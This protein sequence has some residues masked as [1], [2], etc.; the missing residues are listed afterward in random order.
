M[1]QIEAFLKDWF[2][3]P[4]YW[5]ANNPNIDLYLTQTYHSL[6]HEI[7]QQPILDIYN[8]TDTSFK[9][10][11]ILIHDQLSRHFFR[12][13]K[14]QLSYFDK[15]SIFLLESIID[16]IED[17]TPVERCFLLMPYRHT[18]QLKY[19]TIVLD[20]ISKW[21]HQHPTISIYKRFYIATLQSI[22][23]INTQE[24]S[25]SPYQPSQQFSHEEIQ[26]V[27]DT[28]SPSPFTFM[29]LSQIQVFQHP[30][31][32]EFDNKLSQHLLSHEKKIIVS[33]SGGVDSM[34][35]CYLL[36][37]WNIKH[38]FSYE[39]EAITIHYDNRHEQTIE[40]YMVN[41]WCKILGIPHYV[42]KISEIK[43]SNDYDRDIYEEL[44]RKIRFDMYQKRQGVVLLGHNKDDSLENIM[45]N[46][47]KRRSYQNLYGMQ[48]RTE[49]KDVSLLRPL[50]KIWKKDI[51]QFAIDWNIPFVYDSTPSWSDRGKMRD[52][53]IPQMRS[54]SEEMVEGLFDMVDNFIEIY[55]IY[56]NICPSF[57]FDEKECHCEDLEIYFYE[58]LKKLI[59]QIIAHYQL[60][61]IRNKS[62]LHLSECLQKN[63]NHRITLSKECVVQ[64]IEKKLYFYIQKKQQSSIEPPRST[65]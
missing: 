5:F 56:E 58:Y 21:H 36:Y 17:F 14:D 3:H 19:L 30:L 12:H 39:I 64:R 45:S 9:L 49:E 1:N 24:A 6:F 57:I 62:I 53:L 33:L 29:G 60:Q 41:E 61:P 65:E 54:F 35:C 2:S 22:S 7:T 18:F 40:I 32:L 10:G 11:S 20:Y 28:Q 13:Q 27:L 52:I 37:L 25:V 4:D 48:I 26:H 8:S 43:R 34:V 50:L 42:R 16:Q 38:Q 44:T 59:H 31:F 46:I 23:N 15:R 51:L 55:K 63:T 47:K